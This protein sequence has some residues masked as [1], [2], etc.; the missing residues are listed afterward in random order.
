MLAHLY[1]I[2]ISVS[3]LLISNFIDATNIELLLMVM[4]ISMVFGF[5]L[6]IMALEKGR[7]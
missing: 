1:M 6:I 4:L 2:L 3:T 7:R 5:W